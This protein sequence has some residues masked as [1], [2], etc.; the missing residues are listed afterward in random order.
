VFAVIVRLIILVIG[1]ERLGGDPRS[2]RAISAFERTVAAVPRNQ[3]S[4]LIVI[5]RALSPGLLPRQVAPGEIYGCLE[6]GSST[7]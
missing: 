7:C 4:G 5:A 6:F 1:V 2:T 3:N